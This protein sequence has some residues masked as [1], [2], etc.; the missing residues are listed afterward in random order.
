V[1]L[2]KAREDNAAAEVMIGRIYDIDMMI[3]NFSGFVV[4]STISFGKALVV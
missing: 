2:T 3:P 4:Y 1:I